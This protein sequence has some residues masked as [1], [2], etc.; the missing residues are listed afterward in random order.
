M[1][2]DSS[3]LQNALLDH[4]GLDLAG[5][6]RISY[7]LEQRFRYEYDA[8]VHSLRQRLVIVPPA[9]HGNQYLRAHE[10]KVTGAQTRR[11]VR[12]D[13]FGNVIAW[14][15]AERVTHAIEFRLAAIVE[16]VRDD[17][18]AT[19]PASGPAQPSPA[20]PHGPDRTRRAAPRPRRGGCR[21]GLQPPAAGRTHQ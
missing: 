12:R 14:L 3:L 7:A 2:L 13:A 20:A 16:R 18:P 8:P 9:C 19:L 4:R 1:T 5:A 6:R 11:R 15:H 21:A 17:P 10:L